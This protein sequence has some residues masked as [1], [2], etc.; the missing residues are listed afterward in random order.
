MSKQN[1]WFLAL[2][3]L[4]LVLSVYYITMPNDL[5]VT[6]KNTDKK[7]VE[8]TNNTKIEETSS[9]VAMRVSLEEERQNEMDVL[10]EL[11]TNDKSTSEEKNNAYEQLKYLNELQG[12]EE[13]IEKEIKKTYGTNCF[14][15]IDNSNANVVCIASKHDSTLANDI[16]RLVQKSYKNKMFT[17]VKFQKS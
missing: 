13:A 10:Q 5:L 3:S 2:F 4:I 14:V 8:K 12:K 11:L 9:L 7:T 15:K 6:N 16:M 17:T 1:L